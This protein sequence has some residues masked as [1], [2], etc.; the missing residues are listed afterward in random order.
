MKLKQLKSSEIK[1]IREDQLIKQD[2]CCLVCGDKISNDYSTLDH[3]HKLFKDQ[4]I[5]TD[6]AGLC[7]GVLCRDC[8]AWEGRIFSSFR[9]QGLHKKDASMHQMMRNLANY[10]ENPPMLDPD[11]DEHLIHPSEAEKPRKMKKTSY[12]LLKKAFTGSNKK[13]KFP[14]FP[15][16]GKLSKGLEKLFI[17]FNIEVEYLK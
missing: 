9:R 5:G 2:K 12:N 14:A 6:N 10:L 7:R 17:E 3:K 15:K 13:G 11:L 8:N 1:K 4:E 16:S